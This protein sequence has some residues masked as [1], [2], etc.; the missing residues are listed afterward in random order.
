MQVLD[1]ISW[2][3]LCRDLEYDVLAYGTIPLFLNLFQGMTDENKL[4][5]IFFKPIYVSFPVW[6][7]PCIKIYLFDYPVS[8]H[9][10][11]VDDY[12]QIGKGVRQKGK[13]GGEV[14]TIPS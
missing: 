5:N 13:W 7:I 3:S 6:I 12:V 1:N 10:Y 2:N 14:D 9:M 11:T 4:E 8:L